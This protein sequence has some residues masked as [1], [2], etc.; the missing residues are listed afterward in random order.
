MWNRTDLCKQDCLRNERRTYKIRYEEDRRNYRQVP[1]NADYVLA[2]DPSGNF[3]EGKGCTGWVFYRPDSQHVWKFGEIDA[4]TFKSMEEYWYAHLE[5]INN[6][7]DLC[8][9]KGYRFHLVIEDFLLYKNKAVEQT[10]SRFETPKL[11]G[12]IQIFC[13]IYNIPINFQTATSVKKRW[14][15][16]ILVKKGILEKSGNFYLINGCKTNDHIRDALRHAVHYGTF[17]I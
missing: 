2:I 6:L 5:L 12:A 1:A 15:D 13:Y 10:N 14:E 16:N 3:N 11:I 4:S 9:E 8:K 17:K 7:N